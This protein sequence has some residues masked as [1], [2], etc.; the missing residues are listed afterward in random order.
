MRHFNVTF[1]RINDLKNCLST[2]LKKVSE[3]KIWEHKIAKKNSYH[4]QKCINKLSPVGVSHFEKYS[5][6][7]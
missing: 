1:I 6:I 2:Y 7:H 5:E 4:S 3:Q